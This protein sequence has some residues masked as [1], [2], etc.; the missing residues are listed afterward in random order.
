MANEI[1]Y[2]EDLDDANAYFTDERLETVAWDE[3]QDSYRTKVLNHAFNRLFYD[4]RWSLPTYEDAG[5]NLPRLRIIHGEMAYY[6]AQHLGGEDRRMGLR[7]QGVSEAGVIK[8][9]YI[10]TMT[11]P[12][13]AVV[14]AMLEDFVSADAGLY[15]ANLGR[16]E[17]E[18]ANTDV[19]VDDYT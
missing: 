14:E 10:D 3:L 17:N 2:F 9:K 15:I 7:A 12:V 4:A 11:L 5:D 16:D 8:E 18:D 19:D 1:G 6:L 13:P